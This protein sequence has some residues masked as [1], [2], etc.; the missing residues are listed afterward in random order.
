MWIFLNEDELLKAFDLAYNLSK[1]KQ[2]IVEKQVSGVC[3]RL[4]IVDD[5]LLYAVKRLPICVIAD[6]YSSIEKLIEKANQ[7]EA[8]K[9]PWTL[10]NYFIQPMSYL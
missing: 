3:H 6:G 5:K 8:L 4:F 7:K 2:V 9:M 10:Q 1:R